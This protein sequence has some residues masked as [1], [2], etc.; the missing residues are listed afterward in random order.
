MGF[1]P[2]FIHQVIEIISLGKHVLVAKLQLHKLID[3]SKVTLDTIGPWM[4]D[5]LH[6][7]FHCVSEDTLDCGLFLRVFTGSQ[8]LESPA[9]SL[10]R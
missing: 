8:K 7:E 6:Y 2:L 10:A 1:Y 9:S 3:H 5:H 4:G